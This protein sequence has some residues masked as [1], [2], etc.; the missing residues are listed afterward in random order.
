MKLSEVMNNE[1]RKFSLILCSDLKK[2]DVNLSIMDLM[3]LVTGLNIYY[4]KFP[5]AF[6]SE[7]EFTELYNKLND[8]IKKLMERLDIEVDE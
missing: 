3:V 2:V 1:A 4:M 7:A 8:P 6:S 5:V